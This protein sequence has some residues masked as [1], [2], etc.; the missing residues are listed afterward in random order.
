VLSNTTTT[1]TKPT[2][3][4]LIDVPQMTGVKDGTQN[5]TPFLD[6]KFIGREECTP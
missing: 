2:S 3:F 5:T 1:T 6:V 4:F